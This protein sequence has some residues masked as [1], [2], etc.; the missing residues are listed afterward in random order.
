MACTRPGKRWDH[1]PILMLGI[2]VV[3]VTAGCITIPTPRPSQPQE[4][5]QWTLGRV[6]DHVLI[7]VLE[8]Q[9]FQTVSAHPVMAKIAEQGT[10]FTNFHGLFHPSYP[11]Y[12]AMVGGQDFGTWGDRQKNLHALTITDLLEIHHLTWI[13]YAEG[14]PGNCF[15]EDAVGRYVR[16]HVPLLSFTAIQ[17]TPDRCA[18]VVDA[19]TFDPHQL[20]HYAFYSPDLDNDG[21]DGPK[22]KRLDTAAHWLQQFLEKLPDR[23]IMSRTLIVVTFDESKSYL[24]NHIYTVFLGGMVRRKHKEPRR[25]DHYNVLRTIEENFALGTL[26]AEDATASPITHV[27]EPPKQAGAQ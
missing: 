8:N 25:Y 24:H 12:L 9:D 11:N 21:H 16:R 2:A 1:K 26:G 20:P 27:W 14:F 19:K 17:Q 4:K 10:L 3:M 13:Q 18:R 22:E 23:G 15:L 7:I 6:F 5:E